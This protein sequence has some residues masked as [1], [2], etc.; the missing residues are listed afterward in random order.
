M[1]LQAVFVTG[2]TNPATQCWGCATSFKYPTGLMTATSP[3]L[4]NAAP[5]QPHHVK[6][7][8]DQDA[9]KMSIQWQ[10]LNAAQPQVVYGTSAAALSATASANTITYSKNDIVTACTGSTTFPATAS[11]ISVKQG[12]IDPNSIH[13]AVLSGLQ[14][15]TTYFYQV[16]AVCLGALRR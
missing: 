14:P 16:G 2:S 11:M 4:V 8:P 7:V 15:N 6:V 3:V 10:T 5:N 13:K 12:W 9:T 1:D